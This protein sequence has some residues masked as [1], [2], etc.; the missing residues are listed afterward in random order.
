MAARQEEGRYET[1]LFEYLFVCKG[2]SNDDV[3]VARG[4]VFEEIRPGTGFKTGDFVQEKLG[5][6]ATVER[7]L[8][9]ILSGTYFHAAQPPSRE[10]RPYFAMYSAAECVV[11][12]GQQQKSLAMLRQ[13]Q[14]I[15]SFV[16]EKRD[17]PR[18]M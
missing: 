15:K 13:R 1:K 18:R 5:G 4:T 8:G 9:E 2:L 7:F 16:S 14:K 6:G 11:T 10:W 12:L 3:G 17:R